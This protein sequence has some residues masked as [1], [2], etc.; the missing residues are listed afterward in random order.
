MIQDMLSYTC[1]IMFDGFK[2]KCCPANGP[3]NQQNLGQL[4]NSQYHSISILAVIKYLRL[5][6]YDERFF[7]G[8]VQDL[9]SGN[10]SHSYWKWP[11]NSGFFPLKMVMFHSYVSLPEGTRL[12]H[13]NICRNSMI[14]SGNMGETHGATSHLFL[15]PWTD[16]GSRLDNT[17]WTHHDK[18]PFPW[19][20][21]HW[22]GWV[23]D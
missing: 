15:E 2:K 20:W 16:H 10:L 13:P 8:S 1:L 4:G 6:P 23:M 12:F 19:K 18:T 5:S 9:P 3:F 21:P 14:P 11:R 17:R 7:Q 22:M